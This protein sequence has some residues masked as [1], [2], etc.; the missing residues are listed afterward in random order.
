V[1][2]GERYNLMG[3]VNHTDA[4]SGG[5]TPGYQFIPVQDITSVAF[6]AYFGMK[7]SLWDV[8]TRSMLASASTGTPET[9]WTEVPISPQYLRAGQTY[10]IAAYTG[11]GSYYWID[12]SALLNNTVGAVHIGDRIEIQGDAFP[13]STYSGNV[14]MVDF[15]YVLE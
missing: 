13:T 10:I 3:T 14:F 4:A 7:I 6:R 8:S 9:V 12:G 2:V 11:G 15:V 1:Q 5:W